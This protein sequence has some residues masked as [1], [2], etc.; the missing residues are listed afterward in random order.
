MSRQRVDHPSRMG[1]ICALLIVL[2]LQAGLLGLTAAPA[3]PVISGVRITNLSE[4]AFAVTWITNQPASGQVNHGTTPALGSSKGD[5]AGAG[6]HTHHVTLTGLIPGTQ[7]F[8]DVVSDG[9]IDD[10][11]G[12]HYQ[13]TTAPLGEAPP[14]PD[15][16]YGQVYRQDGSTPAVGTI[17]YVTLQDGDG[18]GDAGNAWPLSALVAGNGY[19]FVNLASARR[20]EGSGYFSY[21]PAGDWL[22]LEAEGA[23]DGWAEQRVDTDSHQPVPAMTLTCQPV[24]GANFDYDPSEPWAGEA[25]TFSG[26]VTAG[27]ELITYDWAFGDG[28]GDTGQVVLHTYAIGDDYTVTMTGTNGCGSD[29]YSETIRA[30]LRYDFDRDCDVDIV[31]IMAV[32]SRWNCRCGDECYG[33][34]YDLDD[35]C[36]ID[37][38]D[39]MAVAS[40]WNCRC[41]DDCY[42][43]TASSAISQVEPRRLMGLAAVRVEP[44]SSMV[45]PGETFTVAVEIEGAMDLGGFQLALDFDPAVVQ[46]KEVTLGDF[47]GST[48][49]NIAPLG[50]EIDNDAGTVMFG[51]FGFESQPGP[52]G[53]GVLAVLTLTAQGM[54]SSPLHLENAQVADTGGQ[55]QTV[56]VEDGRVIVGLPQRTYLPLIVGQ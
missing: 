24:E 26:T 42:Y 23:I 50:P 4:R 32:A 15:W 41:G 34:L 48:G 52:G 25:I 29:T 30:T 22:L 21:S 3:A 14:S 8:L 17:V 2:I 1:V 13:V 37:I 44:G 36:D 38:V 56:M 27:S 54:G 31:D 19:W 40:R 10:N 51:A 9:V 46:V 47:L 39:I 35:D 16:A 55:A 12:S 49:R 45:A 5:D 18:G 53:D 7:Y 43:G 33:A 6:P 11:G 20:S 28:N